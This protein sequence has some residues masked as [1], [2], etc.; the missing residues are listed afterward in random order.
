MPPYRINSALAS[1][2]SASARTATVATVPEVQVVLGVPADVLELRLVHL[3][4][5][6]RGH[7]HHEPA[8]RHHLALWHESAGADLGAF[9]HHGAREHHGADA[10]TDIVHDPAGV[11]DAAVPDRDVGAHD[12]GEL[13]RDVEH[14]VVLYVRVPAEGDVVVLI[15]AEHGER[16]HAGAFLDG[17]VADDLGGGIDP[18]AGMHARSAAG[19]APDHIG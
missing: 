9:L 17:D 7:A 1:P 10:D 11:D 5:R 8:C 4:D 6:L 18:R 2:P 13:G 12:A 19:N 16:P 14:G 15:A 3:P